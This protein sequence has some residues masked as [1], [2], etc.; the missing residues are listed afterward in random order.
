MRALQHTQS[1]YVGMPKIDSSVATWPASLSGI[2]NTGSPKNNSAITAK[3][4]AT[5]AGWMIDKW[6]CQG[7]PHPA[8]HASTATS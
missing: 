2:V 3:V 6:R 7:S 5:C 1:Y 4:K 8:L